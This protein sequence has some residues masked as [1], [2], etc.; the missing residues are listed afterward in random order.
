MNQLKKD[1]S[2]IY[3]FYYIYKTINLINSKIYIGQRGIN[4]EPLIDEYLGSGKLFHRSLLK[5]GRENFKKEILEICTK[6]NINEREVFWIKELDSRDIEI[7][8]NI[9]PGGIGVGRGQSHIYWGREE[10]QEIKDK[11]SR[12]LKGKYP[13]G[14]HPN[15]G[16]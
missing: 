6:E 3:K 16:R 5:Y 15:C 7:G 14:E 1:M 4:L 8:Y 10:P 11:I 12:T 2:T 9:N 13:K